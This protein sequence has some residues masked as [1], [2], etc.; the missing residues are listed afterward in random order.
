MT[1]TSTVI[2]PSLLPND[3]S[4]AQLKKLA[5]E[6]REAARTGEADA[7]EQFRL[8]HPRGIDPAAAKLSDAQL[9][10]ARGYSFP[11]WPK[12][13]HFV[14]SGPG[15]E[16]AE[17]CQKLRSAI[18]DNNTDAIR[19]IVARRPDIVHDH[20]RRMRQRYGNYR[21]LTYACSQGQIEAARILIELGSDIRE[22]GNLPAARGSSHIPVLELLTEHGIDINEQVYDWAP[23]I[24]HPCEDL[25][26]EVLKWMLD[27]GADPDLVISGSRAPLTALE[28]ILGTYSRS[29]LNGRMV[30]C[31]E[32]L[33]AA[34]AAH[35]DGPVMDMHR[36]RF[37]ELEARLNDDPDLINRHLPGLHYGETGGRR[38]NARGGTLLH[39]AAEWPDLEAA[40]L[41]ISHGADVNVKAE[42]DADG[43]G[44]QTPLFNALSQFRNHGLEVA[45]FLLAESADHT[46]TAT[47]PGS[48]EERDEM[49]TGNAVEYAARYPGRWMNDWEAVVALFDHH[50]TDIRHIEPASAEGR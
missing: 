30:A 26:A 29:F 47:V 16:I 46:I 17:D 50:D 8:F 24:S 10:I 34:G 5:K 9:V 4:L 44:G 15:A 19:S 18:D 23:L 48:Y 40:E 1:S 49:F 6:L 36:R 14:E 33:V 28:M 20:V 35:E 42:I 38:M 43:V 25:D 45:D 37:K 13:V 3:P 41:L 31:A 22:D 11:S 21:P 32:L 27:H 2:T 12:L 7:L 39:M